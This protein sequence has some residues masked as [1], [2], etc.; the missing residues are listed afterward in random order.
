MYFP[1]CLPVILTALPQTWNRYSRYECRNDLREETLTLCRT[2]KKNETHTDTFRSLEMIMQMVEKLWPILPTS[3]A[4]TLGKKSR[5]KRSEASR[6]S[7]FSLHVE[8]AVPHKTVVSL[9]TYAVCYLHGFCFIRPRRW[10]FAT[11]SQGFR[12]RK[13][14]TTLNVPLFTID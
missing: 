5:A 2:G 8:F 12:L 9:I 13:T 1:T 14:G 10:T 7:S 3:C 4:C 6:G 11:C